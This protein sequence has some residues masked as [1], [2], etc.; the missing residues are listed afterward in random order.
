MT[1]ASEARSFSCRLAGSVK[2]LDGRF[3]LAGDGYAAAHAAA[4]DH[5]ERL[6]GV[7]IRGVGHRQHHLLVVLQDRQ[8]PRI[9]K[10]ASAHLLFQDRELRILLLLDQRQAELVRQGIGNVTLCDHSEGDQQR[11]QAFP[12]SALLQAQRPVE[13]G[14]VELPAL[15]QDLAQPA[16]AGLHR[17]VFDFR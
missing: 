17:Q 13:P 5:L 15:D 6:D 9:T 7:P 1:G 2:P 3:D 11:S 12:R 8:H 14:L 4:G 16:V 10:K